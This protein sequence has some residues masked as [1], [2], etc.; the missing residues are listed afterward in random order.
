MRTLQNALGGDHLQC[1]FT[2]EEIMQQ[3]EWEQAYPSCVNLN[4]L[5]KCL[6]FIFQLM[7]KHKSH[8]LNYT[9]MKRL[10]Q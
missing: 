10:E 8:S 6:N 7:Y 4:Y 9:K 2:V 3:H 5:Q 1:L